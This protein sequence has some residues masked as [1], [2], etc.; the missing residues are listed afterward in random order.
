MRTALW[1]YLR[2]HHVALLALF[3]ALGGTSYAASQIPANSIGSAADQEQGRHVT[4][5][6]RSRSEVAEGSNR[7]H[8]PAGLC[9]S[10]RR[11][12]RMARRAPLG[13]TARRVRPGPLERLA[14]EAHKGRGRAWPCRDQRCHEGHGS[15][16][17][18]RRRPPV[19][20]NSVRR[21]QIAT[22]A[23]ER[24]VVASSSA[25]PEAARSRPFG[26]RLRAYSRPGFSALAVDGDVPDSWYV[27]VLNNTA[28]AQSADGL[29]GLRVPLGD[30]SRTVEQAGKTCS[31]GRASRRPQPHAQNWVL[32]CQFRRPAGV[33]FDA[34]TTGGS[35]SS[36]NHMSGVD[37][38]TSSKSPP[39]R[40]HGGRRRARAG[41]PH[42][43]GPRDRVPAAPSQRAARGTASPPR[44]RPP[45][46][47]APRPAVAPAAPTR[48]AVRY[49]RTSSTR[50]NGVSVA[51]R[52]RVKPPAVTTSRNRA[53][54]AWAPSARPT[55]WSRDAGVQTSVDAP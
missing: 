10:V 35:M 40:G 29:R 1:R 25:P 47:R 34:L 13:T 23:S 39:G 33:V 32:S 41:G 43:T 48:V 18:R 19:R 5:D 22:P 2:R 54:P 38:A 9:R 26:S 50:L 44:L 31:I 16:G 21:R 24:P 30:A 42:S 51:R 17:D 46:R 36:L 55:S 14:S 6:R 11:A 53:S 28:Q 20:T 7:D 37:S 52:K 27:E 3:L 15:H 45:R 4:Q 12:R 49:G 8:R